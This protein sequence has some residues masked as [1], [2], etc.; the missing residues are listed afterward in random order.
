MNIKMYLVG[1]ALLL[2]GA[3]VYATVCW[4]STGGVT[5]LSYDLSNVFSASNNQVGQVVALNQYNNLIGVNATC[6]V[7]TTGTTTKRSYITDLPVVATIDNFQ[8]LQLNDYL[9]G[10][11]QIHDSAAGDFYP[12]VTYYQMGAHPNVSLNRPFPVMDSQLSFRLRV[13]KPFINM[14]PIPRKTL[15]T[16]YVTT[17]SADPLTTPVYIISYSGKI[18]VPQTCE[19]NV[20]QIV[21]FDFGDIASTLF[22]QAGAGNSP[23][24]VTPQTKSVAIKCTNVDAQAYLSLRLEAEKSSGDIMVSDNADLGFKVSSGTGSGPV[25]IPNDT[26]SKLGFQLDDTAR[27]NVTITAVPVSVTGVKPEAGPFTA[28]GYLRVDYD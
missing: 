13:T 15:F 10:A 11:M 20:G 7:G 3:P 21:E 5:E 23:V 26:T 22:S 12:P 1:A 19:L 27:A 4:N 8:Y 2:A 28:R 9:Q 17:T 25:F 14:V 24:G 16:V 6:P 18:E